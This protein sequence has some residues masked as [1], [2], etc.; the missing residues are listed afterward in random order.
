VNWHDS[1]ALLVVPKLAKTED[2]LKK[3]RVNAPQSPNEMSSVRPI[4]DAARGA[5]GA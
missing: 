1:N 2:R 4:D 5:G 3:F